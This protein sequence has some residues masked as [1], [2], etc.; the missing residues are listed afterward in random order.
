[1]GVWSSTPALAFL[2]SSPNHLDAC[3]IPNPSKVM[4]TE[5]LVMTVTVRGVAGTLYGSKISCVIYLF[6][7]TH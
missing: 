6:F 5:K 1:M 2:L 4:I 7:L 3:L